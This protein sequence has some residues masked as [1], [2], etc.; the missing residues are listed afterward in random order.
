MP[1]GRA[2]GWLGQLAHPSV[3]GTCS[4]CFLSQHP[5]SCSSSSEM[6]GFF[7]ALFG[8]GFPQPSPHTVMFS[9]V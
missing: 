2:G 8:A 6:A 5:I 3:W 9:S 4:P 7:S 1:S